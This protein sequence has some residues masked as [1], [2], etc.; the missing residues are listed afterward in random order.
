MENNK[1]TLKNISGQKRHI[2]YAKDQGLKEDVQKFTLEAGEEKTD[3]PADYWYVIEH[4]QP[5]FVAI[6]SNR[7]FPPTKTQAQQLPATTYRVH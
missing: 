4:S 3:L 6:E 7:I 1:V 2:I 5:G